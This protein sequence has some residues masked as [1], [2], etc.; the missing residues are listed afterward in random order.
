MRG[1]FGA[2]LVCLWGRTRK[3]QYS[4]FRA[5][6]LLVV[7]SPARLDLS[8]LCNGLLRGS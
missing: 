2:K 5:L 1:G 8:S 4:F 7:V 3:T 6:D